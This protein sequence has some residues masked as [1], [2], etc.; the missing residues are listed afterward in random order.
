MMGLAFLSWNSILC[1][2]L[3]FI[4]CHTKGVDYIVM[5]L[6]CWSS[7]K[8]LCFY[9]CNY[10]TLNLNDFLFSGII[11]SEVSC[12]SLAMFA[13]CWRHNQIP[14]RLINDFLFV[15]ILILI[16]YSNPYCVT[17]NMGTSYVMKC[18]CNNVRL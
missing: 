12:P 14:Y 16:L 17:F 15:F 6:Q 11:K 3:L 9:I 5:F 10:T 4:Y 18:L 13:S 2:Q 1:C 7:C 8:Y